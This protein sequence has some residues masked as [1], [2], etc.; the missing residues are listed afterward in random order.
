MS[1]FISCNQ[2]DVEDVATYRVQRIQ[3][4]AMWHRSHKIIT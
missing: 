2:F 4:K 3:A 1:K